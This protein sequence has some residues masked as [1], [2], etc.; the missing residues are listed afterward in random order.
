V[1]RDF[2]SVTVARLSISKLGTCHFVGEDRSSYTVTTLLDS[3][4]KIKKSGK[5]IRYSVIKVKVIMFLFADL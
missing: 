4:F 5:S 2:F 1:G 3:D